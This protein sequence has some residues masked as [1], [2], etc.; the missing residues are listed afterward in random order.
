MR[1]DAPWF[2]GFHPKHSACSHGWYRN[3]KPNLM[4]NNALKYR[5]IDPALRASLQAEWNRPVLW[6]FAAVLADCRYCALRVTGAGGSRDRS[7]NA[8][9]CL[10]PPTIAYAI[11]ILIGVNLLTFTCFSWSIRRTTWRACIWASSM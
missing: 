7:T 9:V 4:A 6:P 10:Y 5:R 1:Q 3:V 8:D 2:W 11:P